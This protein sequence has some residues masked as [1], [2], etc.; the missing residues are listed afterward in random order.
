MG[1]LKVCYG[2]EANAGATIRV[3][4]QIATR[5]NSQE[6]RSRLLTEIDWHR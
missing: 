1:V 3:G 5:G 2:S 6:Q 4:S